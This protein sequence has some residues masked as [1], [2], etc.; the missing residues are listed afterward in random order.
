[1][2]IA[3]SLDFGVR[4]MAKNGQKSMLVVYITDCARLLVL[5]AILHMT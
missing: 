4:R 2:E 1:M 5:N 3:S